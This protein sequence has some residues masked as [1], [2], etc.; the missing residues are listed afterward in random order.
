[1]AT[2]APEV[3]IEPDLPIV[4]AHHHLYGIVSESQHYRLDDFVDD[5][6]GGHRVLG[7]V[8]V[9]AFESGW[10]SDGPA[11]FRSVGEVEQVS[12][13]C[14]APRQA[15][16]NLC[17]VA[18]GIVSN[19]DLTL[20]DG[21]RAVL[22]AHVAAGQGR[23]RGV[24]HHAT[25]DAG[26][27]GRFTHSAPAHLLADKQFREG[28]AWLG[29][30]GLSFDALVFHTQLGEVADL[31]DAFP[32]TTFVLNHMGILIGVGQYRDDMPTQM[33]RWEKDL[34]ALALR[35]NVNVKIGGLGMPLS[36]FGFEHG[37]RPA[38]SKELAI[39]WQ[40]R[41]DICVDAFGASRCMFES[42][43]PIDKQSCCYVELWNAFK[44]CT[45]G[46]SVDERSELFHKT[47]CRTYRLPHLHS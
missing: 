9:E 20:G 4:D 26:V 27:V 32:E 18:A 37:L 46:W 44:R 38:T 14:D 11:G 23:L 34:R 30:F 25:R 1:M 41:I 8:Y 17:H 22:E 2:S 13:A 10:R 3:A 19:V 45:Q 39:A 21:V 33:A 5:L 16:A 42:N 36:G 29:R 15:G 40:P 12:A 35:P 7:S 47:V 6:A 28:F 43:F 24:R 31:A